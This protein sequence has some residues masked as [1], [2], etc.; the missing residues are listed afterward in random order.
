[1][2]SVRVLVCGSVKG[3]Y[4]EFIK[5]VNSLKSKIDVVFTVGQFLGSDNT[6]EL[7]NQGASVI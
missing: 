7:Q 2:A 1:M 6:D 5:K 3:K 4:A